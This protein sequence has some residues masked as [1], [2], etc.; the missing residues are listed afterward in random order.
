MMSPTPND[1]IAIVGLSG[2]Y[3]GA[4]D[5]DAFWENLVAGHDA[6]TEIPGERWPLDGFFEPDPDEAAS[7]GRSCS[8]WGAFLKG[9]ADF[10]PLFFRMSPRDAAA[11]DPQ[12]RLFLAAA[13][14]AVEDAGYSPARL[15]AATGGRVG[16]FV[17]ATKTGYALY[18]PFR[19]EGGATVRPST[20]FAAMANRVSFVLDLS[21]PSIPVDTMCSSSLTAI[22]EAVQHL[23][24]GTCAMAIAGG[25]NLYLHPATYADLSASHMLSPTGRC[26]SFGAGAD[27]FVPG[28]GVGCVVLKPLSAALKDGDRIHAVI[29]ASAVNH[30]GRTNGF[31]VPNPLAQRDVVR[32]ALARAGLSAPDISYIEAHGTG[33]DLGDP[34]EIDGL[35]EAFAGAPGTC[36]LGSVK[37]QIGHLE[38]AA[39]IA[40]L[41]K[42]VLQMREKTFAPS[43]YAERLNPNL[44]LDASPFVLQRAAAPWRSEGPRRAGISSFGAGGANAH[45]IVEEG[46]Q[47]ATAGA[48][49]GPQAI[50][51]SARTE[52]RLK[53]YAERLLGF[54]RKTNGSTVAPDRDAVAEGLTARLA[55]LMGVERADIDPTESFDG[56]GLEPSDAHTLV[57]QANADHG[58]D[59]AAEDLAAAGSVSGL[60]N[61]I[62]STAMPKQGTGPAL[63]DIAYTLQVGREPMDAR[64]GMVALSLD[65]L[66]EKL[67]AWLAGSDVPAGV[68]AG[69]AGGPNN[70][71]AGLAGDEVLAEV[72]ARA[73]ATGRAE[74]L[75]R[76]WVEGVEIDWPALRADDRARIVSLPTYPFEKQKYWIPEEVR[77]AAVTGGRPRE[78]SHDA[79]AR[80]AVAAPSGDALLATA[81]EG[82]DA[83][84]AGVLKALLRDVPEA[85]VAE[86]YRPW[87]AAAETLL[88]DTP[89]VDP[90]EAWAAWT[91]RREASPAQWTLA[92]AAL[93]ALPEILTGQIRAT[94]VLFPHGRQ[95]LVEAVYKENAVAARFSRTLAEAAAGIVAESAGR[96]LRIL[97]IGAGTGG[98]SEPVFDALAAHADRIAEYCYTDVSKAFLIHAERDYAGRVPGLKTALFDIERPPQEQDI[99]NGYDLVIAAN[100]L[101]AT[102]DIHRTLSHVRDLL[103]SSGALLLNE[104]GRP[105]LF[106]HVTFGL[107]DGWWRF[108]DPERRIPGTPS[109]TLEGW[110]R[111]LE[112][113]GF[114][115]VAG[116]SEPERALGQQIVVARAVGD[117]AGKITAAAVSAPAMSAA[118]EPSPSQENTAPSSALR[119]RLLAALGE[120]LNVAPGRIEPDKS[121]A[122]Y[123]LDSIL[124]AEFVHRLRKTL[125]IPLDQTTLFDFS[126]V[127]RLEA[128]LA[129]SHPGVAAR[130][131][132]PPETPTPEPRDG[133]PALAKP[134]IQTASAARPEQEPIAIVGASGRFAKSG[135]VDALWQ[136]LLAGDDLV[137]PVTRFDLAPFYRDA[138]PGT[139]GRHGSFLEDVDRFDPVFFGISGLGSD[140]HG[141]PAAALSRRSLEDAGKCGPCGVRYGRAAL[142]RLRRREPRRLPGAFCRPAAGSGVLGQ[143]GL[144]DPG[145]DFL[146]ARP[147][148]AGRCRRHRL[149]LVARRAAHCLSQPLG[150]RV[151]DG[152]CR[153][154]L[155]P[156]LAALLP[157]RQCREHALAVRA[158]RRLRGGGGR[159]RAGRGRR[160]RAAA[161]ARRRARRRRHGARGHRRHRHQ[162]GRHDQRHHGAERGLPGAVDPRD[163]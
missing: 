139:Y 160:R 128:H 19:T 55:D 136:H 37:S 11:M 113:T 9:F 127:A 133:A 40:G 27:G 122:D 138:E 26:R 39:G 155:R 67:R 31:T 61:L 75:L 149:F 134:A 142:R 4:R 144:A 44:D 97:E 125:C 46:P 79:A 36:A 157:L 50:V 84:I 88:A 109:L 20:S 124:G 70:G 147:E 25:V 33:T 145:A 73:W 153:R 152:A 63:A 13:W 15:K 126:N 104:T 21:G 130:L 2:A 38:A 5:L 68:F 114:A 129:E 148:R 140:L 90:E 123:G 102:A 17:G 45:V 120:T 77:R 41:T 3:P 71:F 111:A 8:K 72:I 100:V 35:S 159:H 29:R 76:L 34:I 6:V 47:E 161:P 158:L 62:A 108:T 53:A 107:L 82:F 91:A 59:L 151:R 98:T 7:S 58:T 119:D 54:L 117:P 150:G 30:G 163:L 146:L 81:M 93:K 105:T 101:H 18:G 16:V 57:R 56:L 86:K 49:S 137:E 85:T 12:E 103:A 112:D 48:D 131:A 132:W 65:D 28:E 23:E 92:D 69:N 32:A 51:L 162:P 42:V 43:L 87:R 64:L 66:A 24:A 99:G 141:P 94:D 116:S 52:E 83:A 154:R 80:R 135:T 60:A 143:H 115:F 22:H 118:P 110:R 156:V 121:F 14:Q 106:T 95:S 89:E 74:T 78:Q 96:E 10:D 1:P